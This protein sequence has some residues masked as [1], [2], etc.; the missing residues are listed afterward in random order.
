MKNRW[1]SIILVLSCIISINGC[2]NHTQGIEGE[3][4]EVK[5]ESLSEFSRLVIKAG[6]K[7]FQVK[8]YENETT[9]ALIQQMPMTLNMED[10]N[11]NEKFYY[12]PFQLPSNPEIVSSIKVGDLM[13]YGSDCLVLFYDNFFTSYS[14]TRI[15]YIEDVSD[16]TDALD[17][18][19]VQVI[20]SVN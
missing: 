20:F 10:L 8:L 5:T 19:I 15:G 11:G 7:E 16:F 6:D 4:I 9:K 2:N 3:N 18:G 14:Y 13:L 17:S 12:M 1:K